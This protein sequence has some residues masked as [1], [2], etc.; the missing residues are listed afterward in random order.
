ML[1]AVIKSGS[2]PL[3]SMGNF[4]SDRDLSI[5]DNSRVATTQ[6][7]LLERIE[8][9]LAQHGLS[10]AAASSLAVGNADL[11]RDLK[12]GK[13]IPNAERL[14][15][16]AG[17][18]GTTTDWLLTGQ[19]AEAAPAPAAESGPEI[20]GDPYAAFRNH[21][22][23][24]V[25][26]RG[27]PSCGEIELDGQEIETVE[28]D[29]GD[30]VDYVRRPASLDGRK[31][32][33]AIY[34]TGFSMEPRFDQ[35]EVAYVDATRPPQ[36]GDYVVVQLKAQRGEDDDPRIVHALVKRLVRRTA[37]EITLEQ[38]NPPRSFKV[39]ARRVGA[40]HR[41]FPWSELVSV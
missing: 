25:P 10:A 30:I 23:R 28:M 27:T 3:L 41:I 14:R 8:A 32:V 21:R 22:P 20:V 16:L 18:L 5:W 31:D 13:G 6:E 4:P 33:Y 1:E 12:R 9:K 35:G 2:V 34:F 37:H 40:I 29:A 15:R 38:F 19:G 17:V 36:I 24:D 39:D 7:E 11:I 26:V